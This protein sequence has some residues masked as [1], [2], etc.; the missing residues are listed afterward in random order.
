MKVLIPLLVVFLLNMAAGRERIPASELPIKVDV[1]VTSCEV[2]ACGVQV[3]LTIPPRL[4]NTWAS[5]EISGPTFRGSM[6]KLNGL[7]SVSTFNFVF[8]GLGQGR[9][10]VKGILFD[11][12][13]EVSRQ[14]KPLFIRTS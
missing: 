9:Y 3:V 10:D 14:S 12:H 7:N 5:V 11:A 4:D 2:A 8:T 13:R 1:Q 6:V